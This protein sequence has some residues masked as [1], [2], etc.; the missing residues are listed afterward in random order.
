MLWLRRSRQVANDASSLCGGNWH[1]VRISRTRQIR[2]T[3]ASH[4][5]WPRNQEHK[6]H[7]Y[8]LCCLDLKVSGDDEKP[9]MVV[10]VFSAVDGGRGFQSACSVVTCD[11]VQ[12]QRKLSCKLIIVLIIIDIVLR[13][14]CLLERI[15][16]SERSTDCEQGAAA[17]ERSCVVAGKA[18]LC[19]VVVTVATR[20]KL[21]TLHVDQYFRQTSRRLHLMHKPKT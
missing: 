6:L 16:A 7:T 17:G 20:K 19:V 18:K 4:A 9:M 15:G 1:A 3:G 8:L 11:D 5:L 10:L 21:R 14:S 2:L 13:Q 12:S